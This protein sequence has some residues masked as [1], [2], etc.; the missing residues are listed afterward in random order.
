VNPYDTLGVPK[1][2]KPEE[3]KSAFRREAKRH[4]PDSGDKPDAEAFS[5]ASNA[6]KLL[7]DPARREK[8]DRTGETESSSFSDPI[9]A[10]AMGMIGSYVMQIM[11]SENALTLNIPAE[12]DKVLREEKKRTAAHV[13]K[14]ERLKGKYE[15]AIKKLKRKPDAKGEATLIAVFTSSLSQLLRPIE[16]AKESYDAANRAIEILDSGSYVFEAD[17]PPPMQ[18]AYGTTTLADMM[19][20]MENDLFYGKRR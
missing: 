3:I 16:M 20:V 13:E 12:I 11:E 14:L 4:H 6:H 9:F 17:A 5:R 8:F 1:D 19:R 18:N 10:R 2:A 15:K 7:M